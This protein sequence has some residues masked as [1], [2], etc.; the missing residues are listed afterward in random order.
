MEYSMMEI[1]ALKELVGL[2][3][4]DDQSSGHVFGSALNPGTLAGKKQEELAKPGVKVEVKTFN[5][6]AKGGATQESIKAFEEEQKKRR[7][8]DEKT[9]IWTE[10]EVN[11]KQEERPDDRPQP[12]FDIKYK[13][14]VG[15]EDVFLGLSDKDPSSL[16]C[17]S[18]LV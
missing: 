13:Q 9:S 12:K 8:Q 4:D 2:G 7:L 1:N 17:D 6:D 14:H 10:E 3:K 11:I 18:I 16:H 15:T 5:R